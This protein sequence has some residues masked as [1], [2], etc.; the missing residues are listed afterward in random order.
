MK[1]TIKICPHCNNEF[2]SNHARRIYCSDSHRVAAYNKKKGFKVMLV[3]PDDKLAISKDNS[4]EGL[5][6]IKQEPLYNNSFGKQMGASAIGSVAANLLISAF[7]KEEDKPVT[8][9]DLVE[10][11]QAI[12]ND[13]I[14]FKNEIIKEIKNGN[15]SN[16]FNPL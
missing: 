15:N 5:K 3:A 1:K 11:F 6:G 2:E 10:L 16:Y 9:K 8:K 14:F 13:Q 4:L 12:R 7:T